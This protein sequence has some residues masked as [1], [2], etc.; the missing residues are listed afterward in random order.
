MTEEILDVDEYG[1]IKVRLSEHA[2][3]Q[4]QADVAMEI[5]QK[6]WAALSPS[7]QMQL[8]LKAYVDEHPSPTKRK[9]KP[10]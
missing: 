10:K 7:Q 2:L 1:A 3:K 4:A 9:R 5:V 8:A 6:W